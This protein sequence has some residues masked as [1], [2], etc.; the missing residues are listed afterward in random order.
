MI[1]SGWRKYILLSCKRFRF[2][3]LSPSCHC[4]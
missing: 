1:R 2:S 4:L 3:S